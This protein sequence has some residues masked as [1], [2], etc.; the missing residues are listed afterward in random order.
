MIVEAT[1]VGDLG[2]GLRGRGVKNSAV[3]ERSVAICLGSAGQMRISAA[4]CLTSTELRGTIGTESG[5]V[6]RSEVAFQREHYDELRPASVA[7]FVDR[8]GR[9]DQPQPAEGD[10]V[11]PNRTVRLTIRPDV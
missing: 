8:I 7:V 1:G 5:D 10:R 11:S 4:A 6:R 3:T 9:V 2:H